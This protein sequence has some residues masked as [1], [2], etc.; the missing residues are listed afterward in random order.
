MK[1]ISNKRRLDIVLYEENFSSSRSEA[2]ALIIAGEVLVNGQVVNKPSYIISPT[3]VIQIK[4]AK[5]YVSRGGLKLE[6]ALKVFN[7]DV[8]GRTCI[9]VGA[10]TGGFTDCL[11]KNGAKKVYSVDVGYGQLDYTLRTDD[12]V[13]PM[14]KYN[15]RNLDP[16]DFEDV[17]FACIDV[18]FISIKLI[19]PPLLKC[20]NSQFDVVVLIKPQFEAGKKFVNKGV[21]KSPEIRAQVCQD[22][23]N[24]SLA[25]GY[26]VQGLDYSPIKG[27]KGNIEYLLW[28]SNT[29]NSISPTEFECLVKTV[30]KNS[31][32]L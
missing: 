25:E 19:L 21:V 14:E 29:N 12:R 32:T 1:S 5:K 4:T 11:L 23:M 24:F 28:L 17:S 6:K 18:S 7:I 22:L 13:V 2:Q 30:I 16:N 8:K 20:L 27:P 31:E 10:S 9:D 3:D 26:S 15:A